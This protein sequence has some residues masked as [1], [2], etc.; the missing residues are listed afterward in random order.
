MDIL[1]LLY[2]RLH[3]ARQPTR[4]WKIHKSR[5]TDSSQIGYIKPSENAHFALCVNVMV[6]AESNF[7][8]VYKYA[9]EEDDD[10][11]SGSHQRI[12]KRTQ[13][14]RARAVRQT[15][16]ITKKIW[17]KKYGEYKRSSSSPESC[18]FLGWTHIL[19]V[20]L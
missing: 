4:R 15:L 11:E 5:I 9:T 10:I 16:S 13:W 18:W 7:Y 20:P 19:I 12:K 8:I 17:G 2:I 1:A 3:V 6:H 14:A